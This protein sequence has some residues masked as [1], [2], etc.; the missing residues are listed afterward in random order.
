MLKNLLLLPD[1]QEIFSGGTG[2]AIS[3]VTWTEQVNSETDLAPGAVCA[4]MLEARLLEA[5]DIRL[6]AGQEVALYK[7]DASGNRTSVGI[8]LCEKPV[9]SSHGVLELTAYDRVSLLDKDLTV[10][11]SELKGWPYA[12]EDFAGMV[13]TA[14]GLQL[15]PG[16]L[17]NGD[18]RIH[19][20]SAQGI[21]GRQLMQWVGQ[22]AGRFCR[23]NPR[24]EIELA[25]YTPAPNLG[26]G[27]TDASFSGQLDLR[28]DGGVQ[29]TGDAVMAGDELTSPFLTAVHDGICDLAL[30]TASEAAQLYA[31]QGGMRLSD[32]RVQRVQ[33]VQLKL[34]ADDLG[35]VYPD[36]PAAQNTWVVSGNYL[37]TNDDPLALEQV[38]KNLYGF[39][40]DI[41]YTPC[42][43]TVPAGL[44]IRA[45]HTLTVTDGAG[46]AH[47][48]YVMGKTQTGQR[49]TLSCTGNPSRMGTAAVNA[50]TYRAYV[51]KVMELRGDV[52]GLKAENR[53][54]TGE[55]AKLSLDVEGIET[56]VSRQQ[57][58][59]QQIKTQLTQL[60]QEAG[61]LALLV[62]SITQNGVDKVT[63]ATG[64][65][66]SSDGLRIRKDGGE[67]ENLLDDTGMYV[68]RSGQVILKAN[69]AGVLATD[70]T[71]RNYLVVG[72][73]ARFEDYTDG[74][75]SKRTACF[76]M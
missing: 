48:V 59:N 72:S 63:T 49:D 10:W 9:R 11:L 15:V 16:R 74:T 60:R 6:Q 7:V 8:F 46:V 65:T 25:W 66:F 52:D 53:R 31:F 29:I 40:K 36:D 30:Q 32:Y 26:I 50:R 67:M 34:T 24:G 3:S 51:G 2:V 55:L 45:G 62:G 39:L 57:T 22:I 58:E 76:W 19:P 41:T 61:N 1:G 12:L 17:L 33:K 20:F 68:S 4:A 28:F 5:A 73:Y 70:V 27:I 13:C 37:L 64:Y 23:A 56:Q 21:T 54:A 75:D 43:L 38:A 35:A 18:Y 71:V 44:G 47:T 69:N 42:A 14:C